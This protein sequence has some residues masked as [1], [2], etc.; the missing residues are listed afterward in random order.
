MSDVK[1]KSTDERSARIREELID[2]SL[3]L[4]DRKILQHQI[5][6]L[7]SE[8]RLGLAELTAE[9]YRLDAMGRQTK[10]CEKERRVN[11]IREAAFGSQER[12]AVKDEKPRRIRQKSLVRGRQELA[13]IESDRLP[14]RP[15][16]QP[17]R[18]TMR[19]HDKS[20]VR[21]AHKSEHPSTTVPCEGRQE[22]A[23]IDR[24]E[25]RGSRRRQQCERRTKVLCE[26]PQEWAAIDNSPM[27]GADKSWH[28]STTTMRDEDNSPVRGAHK[29]VNVASTDERSARIREELIDSGLYLGDRKIP[30]HVEWKANGRKQSLFV[31]EAPP[32]PSNKE[33]KSLSE[34]ILTSN[35]GWRGPTN[36]APHL[37]DAKGSCVGVSPVTGVFRDDFFIS[38]E[39]TRTLQ[40]QIATPDSEERPGFA[41]KDKRK[42]GGK[43]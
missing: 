35:A 23:P 15:K 26:G 20:P 7:D 3:Y 18:T 39:N 42:G 41:C 24:D 31:K 19:E 12:E 10:G 33:Q 2:S 1:V 28:P 30:Q 11:V 22:L 5:A 14:G 25:V 6:T 36:I 4:G 21:G 8:E 27:R 40:Q 16:G 32:T 34:D 43:R 38:V 9:D 37:H 17:W 29:N 13:P